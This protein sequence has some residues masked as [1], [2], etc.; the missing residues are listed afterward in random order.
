MAMTLEQIIEEQYKQGKTAIEIQKYL[1][2]NNMNVS[3]T[4]VKIIFNK[5]LNK[6]Q[7]V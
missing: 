1:R 4:E 7:G 2:D 3:F 5:L 6:Y